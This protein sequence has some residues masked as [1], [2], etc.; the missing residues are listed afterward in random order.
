[1]KLYVIIS[2]YTICMHRIF[3][4]SSCFLKSSASCCEAVFTNEQIR[5]LKHVLRIKKGECLEIVKDEA[6]LLGVKFIEFKE[7]KMFGTILKEEK[8][9]KG[10]VVQIWLAQALP[11]Q[12][13]LSEILRKCTELGV[14]RFM[15]VLTSRCDYKLD[16]DKRYVKQERWTNVINS[17]AEQAKLV[18]IPSLDEIKDFDAFSKAVADL[19]CIKIAC[20]EEESALGLKSFLK[21]VDLVNGLP[22]LVFIGPEG[23][24]TELEIQALKT[25]GFKSVSLGKTILR[26]ENA[27]FASISN[28]LYEI[29]F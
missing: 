21:S 2:C 24:I 18:F 9:D 22:I 3:L 29:G 15:P 1:M 17:A 19:N 6:F 23:G 13:K 14:S 20:W 27:G 11:K 26:V 25:A 4:D 12:D 28:I 7:N 5:H 10:N 8:I 16:A